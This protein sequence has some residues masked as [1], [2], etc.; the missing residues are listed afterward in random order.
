[1]TKD[2]SDM[3]KEIETKWDLNVNTTIKDINDYYYQLTGLNNLST[4]D[5]LNYLYVY[6]IESAYRD[7]DIT[8]KIANELYEY[9]GLKEMA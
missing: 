5:A 7:G 4:G 3:I 9:F 6:I 1:M 8:Q 2:F